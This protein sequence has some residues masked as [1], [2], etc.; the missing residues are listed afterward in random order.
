[1][2]Y[3]WDTNKAKSN[4]QKHG[5]DFAD[6]VSVFADDF[7]ITVMD[8]HPDEERFVTIGMD[9]MSIIIV[10]VYTLR[11]DSCIRLISACKATRRERHQYESEG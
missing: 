9:A 11:A 8:E 7:A 4:Y 1:M 5:I 6:A 3:E 2:E 10:V